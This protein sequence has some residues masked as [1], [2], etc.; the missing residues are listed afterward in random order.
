[1]AAVP[2][3]PVVPI[4]ALP[5]VLMVPIVEVEPAVVVVVVVGAVVGRVLHRCRWWRLVNLPA[6]RVN[7]CVQN[8]STRR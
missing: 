1:M 4:A 5:K 2:V 7:L 8:R 3:V 6:H